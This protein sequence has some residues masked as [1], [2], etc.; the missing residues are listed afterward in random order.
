[1][2]RLEHL[3]YW[4]VAVL[5]KDEPISTSTTRSSGEKT[6][7]CRQRI[8]V[9]PESCHSLAAAH[10]MSSYASIGL[11]LYNLDPLFSLLPSLRATRLITRYSAAHDVN[12]LSVAVRRLPRC[13]YP[14]LLP[15]S[16]SVMTM[17]PATRVRVDT[18]DCPIY[19]HGREDDRSGLTGRTN[20]D[21]QLSRVADHAS[22]S[23]VDD[24]TPS[25]RLTRP[26]RTRRLMPGMSGEKFSNGSKIRMVVGRSRPSHR[27]RETSR[28]WS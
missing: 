26:A 11:V 28:L 3:L 8:T 7:P 27:H 9:S 14:R 2:N 23:F 16:L 24:P 20:T 25:R 4:R 22:G 19:L 21:Q 13:Q 10:G 15:F 1:M 18:R 5:V 17:H 12:G 6:T